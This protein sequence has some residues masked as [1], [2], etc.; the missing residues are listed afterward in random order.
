MHDTTRSVCW[1]CEYLFK[2]SQPTAVVL[3]HLIL[4]GKNKSGCYGKF[5]IKTCSE[6]RY[7]MPPGSG[8]KKKIRIPI[9]TI[10]TGS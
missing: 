10:Q 5:W 2:S 3:Q 8:A 7:L 6:Y 4:R 1:S 9:A